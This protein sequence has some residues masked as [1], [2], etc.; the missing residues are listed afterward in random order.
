MLAYVTVFEI[1]GVHVYIRI[2]SDLQWQLPTKTLLELPPYQTIYWTK[3]EKNSFK[4][5][6]DLQFYMKFKSTFKYLW[7]VKGFT[8][9]YMDYC[10]IIFF[11]LVK[12]SFE[13]KLHLCWKLEE[14]VGVNVWRSKIDVFNSCYRSYG[15]N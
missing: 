13:I 11:F 4:M 3:N 7:N 12:E 9:E 6:R 14:W 5:N 15:Y 2:S 1:F 8:N 10:F